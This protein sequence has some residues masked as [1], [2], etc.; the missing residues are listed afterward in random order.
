MGVLEWFRPGDYTRVEQ[1]SAVLAQ[2]GVVELRTGV[3]WA[4]WNAPGGEAWYAWLLP[5]LAQSGLR[6]LPCFLYT[7]PSLG[8]EY[9]TSSP[10]RNLR[11][12]AD[13]I[14]LF[15]TRFGAG[16]DTVEL[17][18]EANNMSEW[19]WTLD[20]HWFMFAEMVGGAAHWAQQRGK[21]T[22]LGGMSPIDPAWLELMFT[23]GVMQY[24]DI[25]GI[26]GFPGTWEQSW[27]SWEYEIDKVRSLLDAY[28]SPAEIWITETGFSTWRHDEFG[29]MTAFVEAANTS[30]QRVY[31]YS[32]YDL[33][34]ELPTVEGFHLDERE[35]HF[36]LM[37]T[38]GSPKL[39]ARLWAEYGLEALAA[40]TLPLLRWSTS[41]RN[42]AEAAP[43]YVLITGGA[44]FLG[45]HIA[46]DLLS[47][48][49]CVL[50]FDSLARPG[51][52]HNLEWLHQQHGDRLL[53]WP[54]DVRDPFLVQAAVNGA[55][56]VIHLAA[57]TS[58][59]AAVADP[60]SDFN[61]NAGGTLN[62]LAALRKRADRI[63]LLFA[64]TSKVY[65]ALDGLVLD[66][67]DLRYQA[68][69]LET[70]VYGINEGQPLQFCDPYGCSKGAADQYVLDYA[71]QFAIPAVVL[72]LGCIYGPRQSEFADQ[73][74]IAQL[75]DCILHSRPLVAPGNGKQVCDL[76]FV[77]D[78]VQAFQLA[79]VHIQ[80]T[81]GSAYNL[82][83][84]PANS[85][86]VLEMV[87]QLETLAGHKAQVTFHDWQHAGQRFYI[88][89]TA[90]FAAA[91][92]WCPTV[93][94]AQG[95]ARLYQWLRAG[96]SAPA[97]A[98]S[99]A[100]QNNAQ[101]PAVTAPQPVSLIH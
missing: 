1:L 15:I 66:E 85:A 35:Y 56:S 31:W 14:D 64:S 97:S 100:R 82:G 94:L 19:D 13:F 69:D 63:P 8:L 70:F 78:L 49:E 96:G 47:R 9:K 7:P 16:F 53:V 54:A 39:L 83:G 48:G 25:V 40:Q 89:D 86:S 41:G 23:R 80:R 28:Q 90:K 10:P 101:S 24:I 55:Q 84:G 76:L 50:I 99:A 36:G 17:W 20:P 18:N 4:E 61:I 87:E 91:T 93:G 43:P 95:V 5:R 62:V 21:R 73:G 67:T 60:V 51:V 81:A 52:E 77:D 75:S 12:Y 59:A 72:R 79:L 98:A 44:G 33:A 29:Q 32:A 88:A 34:P 57:Q 45:V 42:T 74:W 30:V 3:S 68:A 92:G 2:L 22:V 58:I 37:R 38:D 6:V 11:A 27:S 46:H 26:H 65:G 71:R